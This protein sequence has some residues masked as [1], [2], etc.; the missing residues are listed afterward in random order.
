MACADEAGYCH[1]NGL[2]MGQARIGRWRSFHRRHC[3]ATLDVRRFRRRAA[4]SGHTWFLRITDWRWAMNIGWVSEQLAVRRFF[5]RYSFSLVQLRRCRIR[6]LTAPTSRYP[7]VDDKSSISSV[8]VA[9]SLRQTERRT[10]Y[11]P[12]LIKV[13]SVYTLYCTRCLIVTYFLGLQ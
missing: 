6:Y 4:E 5:V 9:R 10:L 1:K 2:F 12:I 3:A 8:S 11:R 7:V 13:H